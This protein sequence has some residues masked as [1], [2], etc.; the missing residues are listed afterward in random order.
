M[1]KKYSYPGNGNTQYRPPHESG[2][3]NYT[4]TL[5]LKLMQLFNKVATRNRTGRGG[6]DMCLQARLHCTESKTSKVTIAA[7]GLD[8]KFCT[9]PA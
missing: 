1:R 9:I 4:E 6:L 3:V 7:A 8:F 2:P 5:S